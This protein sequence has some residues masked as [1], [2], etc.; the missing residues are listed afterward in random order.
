MNDLF[1]MI[2]SVIIAV[3][4]VLSTAI[5]FIF[6]AVMVYQDKEASCNAHSE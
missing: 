6:G 5:L 3:P 1:W 2:L 4:L